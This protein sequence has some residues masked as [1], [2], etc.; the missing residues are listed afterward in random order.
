MSN[1]VPPEIGAPPLVS[2]ATTA[3]NSEKWLARA[4]DSVFLQQTTFPIEIVVGDDCSTDGTLALARSYQEWNPQL[5]R[6]LERSRN[7]GMQ[8]NYYETFDTCR[9]KYIA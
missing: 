9:G 6:V 5:I 4:L 2:V 3:F 8:R 1:P 7:L